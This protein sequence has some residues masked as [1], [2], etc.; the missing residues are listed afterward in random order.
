MN[1]P[2]AQRSKASPQSLLESLLDLEGHVLHSLQ[3]RGGDRGTTK[4]KSTR[5]VHP[6]TGTEP[7]RE[8]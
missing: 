2:V 5:R 6:A 8:A 3:L 7:W 1:L 4:S